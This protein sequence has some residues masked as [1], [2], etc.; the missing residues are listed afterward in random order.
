M[1]SRVVIVAILAVVVSAG[2]LDFIYTDSNGGGNQVNCAIL[3]D[4]RAQSQCYLDKAIAAND[5]GICSSVVVQEFTDT[6]YERLGQNTKRIDI[7]V[8]VIDIAKE[9]AC[10]NELDATYV[11]EIACESIV[12]PDEQVDCYRQ[13]ARSQKQTAY[14]D[15]TGMQKNTCLA[16]VAIAAKYP[17]ICDRISDEGVRDTCIVDAAV[18]ARDG[19]SCTRIVSPVKRDQCHSQIAVLQRNSSLCV[20]VDAIAERT[21]CYAQVT[22]AIGNDSSCVNSSDLSA[23]D[24]CYL[25]QAKSEK[26][27]DLCTKIASQQRRDD[28]YS[29]LAGNFSD[30]SLCDSILIESNRVPCIEGAAAS[31]AAVES[32]NALSGV[33]RDSCITSNALTRKDP[34]LCS[35][36]RVI[37]S[38]TNYRDACYHD[39]S[40]VALAPESCVNIAGETLRDDCYF[41]TAS[42][43]NA[44]PWCERIAGA[45]TKDDC[46]RVIGSTI[47]DV[48]VCE[49]IVEEE[50]KYACIAAIALKAKQPGLCVGI[51]EAGTRDDC[52]FDVAVEVDQKGICEK[53]N[54]SST[55]YACYKEVAIALND[56]AYCN[57]IP[58]GQLLLHNTCLEPIA[59]ATR[60]MEACNAMF[61]SAVKGQ[62]Y[63]VVA[64]RTNNISF[65][66]NIPLGLVEDANQAHETRDYCY[67]ALAGETNDG[68]FCASIYS[69]PIKSNCGP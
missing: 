44:S 55:K 20:K 30:P 51:K 21:A 57:N 59:H 5:P 22:E 54:L 10:V 60:N 13:L 26:K 61:G 46:F 45:E 47:G 7:C 42:D 65:C 9:N 31:T 12:S 19:S 40:I 43:L 8:K 2:C 17:D 34:S 66:Q 11:T 39:V 52:Y 25:S 28:C 23:Q 27:V 58:V 68:S 67:S 24:A 53:I 6:C 16:E 49:Q 64:A 37:T 41:T 56:W 18:A 38:E 33:L 35:P 69:Y 1:I 32:C 14:C 3:S 15:R 62:C 29:Y 36:L 4:A 50:T 63:G 48:S